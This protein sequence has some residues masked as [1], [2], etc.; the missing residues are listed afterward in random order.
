LAEAANHILVSEK[1]QEI[2][3]NDVTETVVLQLHSM[4]MEG[5][6]NNADEGHPGEYRKVSTGVQGSQKGRA[7]AADIHALMCQWFEKHLIKGEGEHMVEFLA[8][9][10]SQFHYIRPFRDDNGRLAT[11]HESLSVE[12]RVSRA[13]FP[14]DAEQHVQ[15]WHGNGTPW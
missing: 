10:H 1:L 2:A 12:R 14:V 11:C 4:V 8:R 5:L 13:E 6:L 9:I 3:R 7:P 15:P